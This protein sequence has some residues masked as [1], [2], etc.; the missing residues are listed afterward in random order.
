MEKIHPKYLWKT[1]IEKDL[2]THSELQLK[3]RGKYEHWKI[4][5]KKEIIEMLKD[6]CRTEKYFKGEKVP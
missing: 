1:E 4:I 5:M 2:Q 6:W 3:G